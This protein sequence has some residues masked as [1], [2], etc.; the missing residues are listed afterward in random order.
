VWN[1]VEELKKINIGQKSAIEAL[2]IYDKELAERGSKE[3]Q[4]SVDNAIAV[5]DWKTVTG[6]A[7]YSKGLKKEEK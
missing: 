2:G 6:S 1:L 7:V 3:V 5:H 4:S